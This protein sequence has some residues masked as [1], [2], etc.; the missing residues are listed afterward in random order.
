MRP[1]ILTKSGKYF[2][3][4]TPETSEYDITD[5]AHALSHICRFGGHCLQFYSVAQHCVMASQLVDPEFRYD[6]LLHDAAEAFIG[7]ITKPLKRLL[8]DYQEIEQRVEAAVFAKFGVS[9]PLPP[10]VKHIDLVLLA[11][12]QR[13]LAAPHGDE[14]GCLVGIQPLKQT[15]RG[16]DPTEAYSEFLKR[17]DTLSTYGKHVR[18]KG[19]SD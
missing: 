14:W 11:T 4:L 18:T 12:E 2:N 9:N 8:P 1:D 5:I 7:D 13:D 17:Y 6:A 3:F 19:P 10:A 16:W 15:I